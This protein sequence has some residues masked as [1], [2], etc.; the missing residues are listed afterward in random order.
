MFAFVDET[1]NTGQNL[2]DEDQPLFVTG[3]LI[4]KADFDLVYSAKVKQI[5]GNV[6]VGILHAKELGFSRIEPIAADVLKLLKNCD[7]RFFLSRVEKR[8]LAATKIVDTIFDSGENLAVPW[9]IYN[10]RALRLILVFKVAGLLDE[11]LAKKFWDCL[12]SRGRKQANELFIEVCDL[13]LAR[14]ANLPDARSREMIG[15]A[16]QWAR[17]NP[18]AIHFYS[19]SD[20]SRYAHLPNLV[21][22]TNLIDGLDRQ[23]QAWARPVRLIRHDRQMQFKKNFE[24]VHEMVTNASPEPFYW[25]GGEKHVI[26]K[27]A[28]STFVMSSS[29][30]SAGIQIV[31]ILLWLAMRGF[32]AEPLPSDCFRL[33]NYVVRRARMHDFSYH[34]VSK[35]VRDQY[36]ERLSAPL[37]PDQLAKAKEILAKFEQQ[38][39]QNLREYA[40]AKAAGLTG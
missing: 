2:F 8:Y 28:G 29:D 36:G 20:L 21:A 23:S 37:P 35:A 22:F 7:A 24:F 30:A 33:M 26:Q 39:Q 1:G 11:K 34:G 16:V 4:T 31:D 25:A 12:M 3:A 32:S 5:A 40:E 15:E 38:R 27:V 9:Q 14:V 17:D 13:L 18:E 6:G 19:D 10:F